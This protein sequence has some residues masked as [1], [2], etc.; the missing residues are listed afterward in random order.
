MGPDDEAHRHLVIRIE[1]GVVVPAHGQG[2]QGLARE[3][4]GDL[5][6]GGGDDP[7]GGGRR[8]QVLD[9]PLGGPA[10]LDRQPDGPS[11]PSRSVHDRRSLVGGGVGGLAVRAGR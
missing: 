6:A 10:D 2:Q 3:R 8:H 11:E 4:S 1:V 5:Q 7:L 9:P